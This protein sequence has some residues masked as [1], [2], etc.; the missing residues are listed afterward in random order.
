MLIEFNAA[1]PFFGPSTKPLEIELGTLV[2]AEYSAERPR[3]VIGQTV[4]PSYFTVKSEDWADEQEWRVFQLLEKSEFKEVKDNQTIHLFKLPPKAIKRIVL[5][6]RM[7]RAKRKRLCD[8]LAAN[9]ELHNHVRVLEA[10]LDV[11]NFRLRYVP[12]NPP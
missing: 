4:L 6:C 12:F 3:H 7:D 9:P 2:R 8:A 1:H 5:G 11:D 10:K